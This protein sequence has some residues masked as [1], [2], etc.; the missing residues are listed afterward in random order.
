MGM[1]LE[2]R[3]LPTFPEMQ[4]KQAVQRARRRERD[5]RRAREFQTR[6]D[7]V[8]AGWTEHLESV[9]PTSRGGASST[10]YAT[11]GL[12]DH[13]DGMP[14]DWRGHRD[15]R[16]GWKGHALDTAELDRALAQQSRD[17]RGFVL[18]KSLPPQVRGMCMGPDP[19]LAYDCNGEP[20]RRNRLR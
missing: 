15:E 6:Q 7:E 13:D 4:T 10:P 18:L 17:S 11:G 3:T 19:E 2:S 20:M 14:E 16:R 9:R 1:K 5:A 12:E 8:A